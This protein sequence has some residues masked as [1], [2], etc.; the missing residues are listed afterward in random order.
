MRPVRFVQAGG[1]AGPTFYVISLTGRITFASDG[2]GS[3]A[4]LRRELLQART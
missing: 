1:I 4:L 2:E 3:D